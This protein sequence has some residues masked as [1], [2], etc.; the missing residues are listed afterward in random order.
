ML[1]KSTTIYFTYFTW[2][3]GDDEGW[4]G[5][6]KVREKKGVGEGEERRRGR[7]WE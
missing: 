4:K 6:E 7:G 3:D 1:Y 2:R 5:K